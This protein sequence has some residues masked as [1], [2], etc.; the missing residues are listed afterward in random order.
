M[1]V[2][3]ICMHVMFWIWVCVC[4]CMWFWKAGERRVK[5]IRDAHSNNKEH[6]LFYIHIVR[7]F[8]RSSFVMMTI[9][10]WKTKQQKKPEDSKGFWEA[11]VTRR[12]IV[13]RVLRMRL[14][15]EKNIFFLIFFKEKCEFRNMYL[16]SIYIHIFYFEYY[17]QEFCTQQISVL[18]K[19][20]VRI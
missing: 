14:K 7:T 13:D 2:T 16:H 10:T 4:V 20:N 8:L 12:V 5:R 19:T 9:R 11:S 3:N 15:V 18:M 6:R 17:F 1:C